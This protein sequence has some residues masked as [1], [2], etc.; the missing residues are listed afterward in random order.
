[1]SLLCRVS[2]VE[3]DHAGRERAL[4]AVQVDRDDVPDEVRTVIGVVV[5]PMTVPALSVTVARTV[6]SPGF[7]KV[8]SN[9][10]NCSDAPA[11]WSPAGS[12]PT[13]VVGLVGLSREAGRR[14]ASTVMLVMRRFA[15]SRSPGVVAEHDHSALTERQP[16]D[17]VSEMIEAELVA[18][19]TG[20][21]RQLSIRRPCSA[22]VAQPRP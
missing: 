14:N 20:D 11:P 5:V 3:A 22:R 16:G 1:M 4:A 17:S 13:I 15:R 12:V 6:V 8:R 7:K 18:S 21:Q 2:G 19:G 9:L 10:P